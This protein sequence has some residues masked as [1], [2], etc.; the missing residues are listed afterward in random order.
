[1]K[2]NDVHKENIEIEKRETIR[3]IILKSDLQKHNILS[4]KIDNQEYNPD[5]YA[6]E[7]DCSINCI[8][9][10]HLEGR[11]IY[12]DSAVFI[13]TKAVYNLWAD[14]MMAVVEHSIDD[15]IFCE[16][17]SDISFTEKEAKDI[18]EEMNRIVS[19]EIWINKIVFP[20]KDAVEILTRQGRKDLIRNI[21][22]YS[23]REIALYK[24]GDYYD[25]YSRPLADNTKN[26]PTFK[27]EYKAPGF[28][29]RFPSK[30]SL[31]IRTNRKFSKKVFAAHQLHDKWLHNLRVHNIIDLNKLNDD[32]NISNFILH[33]EALHEKKI[34]EIAEEISNTKKKL[35]LIAGP[36]SSGKTTFSHR[37][38]VQ[39][40]VAGLKPIVIGLD[41]Y[42][43]SRDRTPRKENGDYNFE[44]L[45]ALDLELLNENLKCLLA[46][47]SVELPKYN[48][49]RGTSEKSG[50]WIKL[51]EDNILVMEGIHGLNDELTPHISNESKVKIYVTA[52]NQLNI[53]N[54]NR[55]PT[56][57]CRKLR[58][59][60]RDFLYRGYTAEETL[61]RWSDVREGENK[62]IFPFQEN[63]DY[64]FNSGLT[65]ELG[66][67][68]S[69]AV[70]EL[71]KI[72]KLSA[73]YTEAH[74]L[75]VLLS[76][77]KDIPEK[78]IPLN[79]LL[80][81]FIGGSIFRG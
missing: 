52:L 30:N 11:R 35:I 69:H 14:Q 39:L 5:S 40:Q 27:I 7:K 25:F 72:S 81:E 55:I 77:I 63:A 67:I 24:C 20:W 18:Q 60:V 47:E 16:I 38:A 15:G 62:N 59:L 43:V 32:Y 45:Q 51:E 48:F 65:Y 50:R 80:R 46:G 76:F 64:I 54:H 22:Y 12:Q 28:I 58:R 41:D 78:F 66:C 61:S 21:N 9:Y 74:R 49:G 4:Y 70:R 42:F 44:C 29:L 37:L 33:E 1:M 68:K 31:K 34:A 3:E 75:L 56:T 79:S 6:I 36:S 23:Y 73:N 53:D 8:T 10:N 57:D 19:R 17:F 13:M 2:L 26:I 71:K